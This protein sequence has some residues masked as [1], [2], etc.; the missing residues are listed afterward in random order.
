MG[1]RGGDSVKH[2]PADAGDGGDL[3]SVP[4]SGKI[5]WGEGMATHSSILAWR[6]Q[7]TE[8]SLVGFNPKCHKEPGTTK[9]T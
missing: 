8:R 4:E 9:V 7:W 3:G 6:I 2:L 5:P 1:F